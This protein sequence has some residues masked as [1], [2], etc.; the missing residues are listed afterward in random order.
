MGD[1]KILS[2]STPKR[3]NVQMLIFTSETKNMRVLTVNNKND[4]DAPFAKKNAQ[5]KQKTF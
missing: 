3:Q 4:Y 2:P 1:I 5:F